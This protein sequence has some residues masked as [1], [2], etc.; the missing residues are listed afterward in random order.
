[1]MVEKNYILGKR[2]MLA[3]IERLSAER[4]FN[5]ARIDALEDE[6]ARLRAVLKDCRTAMEE[7]WGA[8]GSPPH[9]LGQI[10]AA[11]EDDEWRASR[12]KR[13]P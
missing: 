13:T 1:M 7:R 2:D 3:E 12:P 8:V 9:L 11:L 4:N 6:I 10:R 5:A